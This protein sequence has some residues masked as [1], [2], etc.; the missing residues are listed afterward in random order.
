VRV[1]C[2]L[3]LGAVTIREPTVMVNILGDAWR[4]SEGQV[5]AE[6][7]WTSVLSS[8]KVKLHLYG[9]AQP[10]PGRKMGHFTVRDSHLDL[11]MARAR[12]IKLA[13]HGLA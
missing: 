2:G 10:R 7:D 12:E 13:L 3:P 11:A 4:W 6:P 9:N 5:V 8:P 1:V